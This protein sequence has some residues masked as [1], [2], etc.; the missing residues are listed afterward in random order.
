VSGRRKNS[1]SPIGRLIEKVAPEHPTPILSSNSEGSEPLDWYVAFDGHEKQHDGV[2][3]EDRFH[4]IQDNS[5]NVVIVRLDIEDPVPSH[6]RACES[7]QSSN[8]LESSEATVPVEEIKSSSVEVKDLPD[9]SDLVEEKPAASAD[10][11]IPSTTI[12]EKKMHVKR[13][14]KK[15]GYGKKSTDGSGMKSCS[16]AKNLSSG[17]RIKTIP[18]KTGTLYIYRHHIEFVRRHEK[19]LE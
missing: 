9:Q 18:F 15:K 2:F 10:S 8:P 1:H 3:R 12:N 4:R 5:A 19:Y 6:Q 11:L 16:P 14:R 17:S 7:P 13:K